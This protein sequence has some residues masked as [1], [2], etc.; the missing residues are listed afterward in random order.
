MPDAPIAPSPP[1]RRRGA[2]AWYTQAQGAEMC[3]KVSFIKASPS[4]GPLWTSV[5]P[6]ARQDTDPAPRWTR[7]RRR[8]ASSAGCAGPDPPRIAPGHLTGNVATVQSPALASPWGQASF[9]G[10]WFASAATSL[11]P[12]S[13]T[14]KKLHHPSPSQTSIVSH[15]YLSVLRACIPLDTANRRAYNQTGPPGHSRLMRTHSRSEHSLPD[16][17]SVVA[18]S[19]HRKEPA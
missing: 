9:S 8:L 19:A 12:S 3:Y 16:L 5:H 14:Q 7:G 4:I 13:F 10:E 2:A 17:F 15:A 6:R 11:H 1:V 18:R